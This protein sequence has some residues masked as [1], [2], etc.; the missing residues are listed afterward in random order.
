MKRAF[1]FLVFLLAV[2]PVFLTRALDVYANPTQGILSVGYEEERLSL[3][4]KDAPLEKVLEEVAR[5]AGLTVTTDGPVEGKVTVHIESLPTDAALKKILRGKDMTLHYTKG[6]DAS[7]TKDFR[8]TE[9]R[10]FVA[11]GDKGKERVFSYARKP[12]PKR[13]TKARPRSRTGSSPHRT[14]RPRL[15]REDEPDPS[16]TS[17]RDEAERF[18]SGLMEGDFDALNEVAERLR[19]EN[20]EVQD[21]IDQFVESLEQARESS[22]EGNPIPSMQGLGNL[23]LIMQRMMKDRD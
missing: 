4:T 7:N 1:I 15:D 20:P 11:E 13:T 12:R 5:L 17:V 22:E 19:E 3:R 2:F 8:L 10:V 18:L 14:I 23:G 9:V 6:A 16:S 21:Q